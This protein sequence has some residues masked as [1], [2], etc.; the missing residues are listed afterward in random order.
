MVIASSVA[1]IVAYL[2][3]RYFEAP[4]LRLKDRWPGQLKES[5][6]EEVRNTAEAAD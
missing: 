6:T 5:K 4:F 1:V 3:Q 2:S